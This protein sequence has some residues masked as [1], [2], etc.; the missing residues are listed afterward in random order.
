MK[1]LIITASFISVCFA[2]NAWADEV[3]LDDVITEGS[4]CVGQDCRNGESFGFDTL[5]L[6]ENNTRLKFQDTSSSASFPRA[7]WQLT[8]NASANG[9]Q[10]YFGVECIDTNA[11]LLSLDISAQNHAIVATAGGVGFGTNSPT[12]TIDSTGSDTP[13]LS[14]YQDGSAGWAP[15]RWDVSGN[16]AGFFVRNSNENT[17][18]LRVLADAPQHRMVLAAGGVGVGTA[19]PKATVHLVDTDPSLTLEDDD[20]GFGWRMATEANSGSLVINATS[21]ESGIEL[22]S[23]GGLIADGEI[24]SRV[25]ENDVPDYVFKNGYALRTLASTEAFIK[26]NGHLPSVPSAKEMS[27]VG[28]AHAAFQL[29]LLEKVEELTLHAIAQEKRLKRLEAE[30]HRLRA[31]GQ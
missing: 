7:D 26:K 1:N 19:S 20:D 14:L 30:N 12:R 6:K 2:G 15:M 24:T 27:Q 31:R 23:D 11:R 18:P 22:T 29:K 5:R 3:T 16:E 8:A 21:T 13:A 9:G 25:N 17:L 10:E 4:Q 28:L